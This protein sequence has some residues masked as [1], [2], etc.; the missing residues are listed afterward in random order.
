MCHSGDDTMLNIHIRI[1][2]NMFTLASIED[3][4]FVL[5]TMF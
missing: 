3:S 5:P 2:Y 1:I 4:E